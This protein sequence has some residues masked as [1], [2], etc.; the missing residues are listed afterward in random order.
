[1]NP[2]TSQEKIS[3]YKSAVEK[4]AGG[5]FYTGELDKMTSNIVNEIKETKTS[6]MKSSKKTYVTDHPEI[7]VITI[8]ILFF[9]LI[10]LEKIIKI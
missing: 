10:I 2:R 1:M 8:V 5:K 4:N 6:L 3:N 7:F 9:A